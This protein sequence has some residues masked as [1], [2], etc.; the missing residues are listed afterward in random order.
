MYNQFC[1]DLDCKRLRFFS[2]KYKYALMNVKLMT[3]KVALTPPKTTLSS[4]FCNLL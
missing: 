1:H 4:L 3:V 2:H